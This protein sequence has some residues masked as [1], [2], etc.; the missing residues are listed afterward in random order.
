MTE[1]SLAGVQF[2]GSRLALV[3]GE[4]RVETRPLLSYFVSLCQISLLY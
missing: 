2:V 4:A 1:A 3:K